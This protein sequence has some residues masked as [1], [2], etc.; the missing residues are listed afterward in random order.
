MLVAIVSGQRGAFVRK[1]PGL[2]DPPALQLWI[3]VTPKTWRNVRWKWKGDR[4]ATF[5]RS[6]VSGSSKQLSSI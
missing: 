1:T 5:A 2:G 6:P 4:H 3:G